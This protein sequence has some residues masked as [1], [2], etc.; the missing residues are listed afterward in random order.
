LKYEPAVKAPTA[1]IDTLAGVLILT[2]TL[3]TF[4]VLHSRQHVWDIAWLIEASRHWLS[5]AVIYR[6][7]IEV[8][9]PLIF[10]E[11]VT[12]TGGI[13]TDA[14]YI[15]GVCVAMALS[16]LWVL[17][18]RGAYVALAAMTAMIV[19]G[20]QDFGQ[21]DHL[22]LIFGL[23]LILRH[24]VSKGEGALLGAWSFLGFGLK[25]YLM[26]IPLADAAARARVARSP[27]LLLQPPYLVL[28]ALGCAY[29][30]A[31]ALF[32]P[33]YFTKMIPLARFVYWAFGIQPTVGFIALS[34]A[35]I[36][37]SIASWREELPL[38]AATVAAVLSF[39]I[40]GRY[41]TYHFVPALG[42]AMMLAFLGSPRKRGFA[43][44]A[45]GLI[46]IQLGQGLPRVPPTRLP[47]GLHSVAILST[48]VRATYP[49]VL[50]RG[51]VNTTRYPALWTLPGAWSI[52]NDPKRSTEDRA[53]AVALL[54]HERAVIRGDILAG[55][56]QIIMADARDKKLYF[57]RPFDY[58]RFLG[59][60]PGYRYAGRFRGYD[61]YIRVDSR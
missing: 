56:P 49:R 36:C 31:V 17:R 32:H 12:L 28:G 4:A 35:T 53:R 13:L 25:P 48:S 24:R 21:R 42:F 10:Y 40:Q 9:P 22:A 44:V 15:G 59:P 29:V 46:G 27:R 52:A 14:A 47:L 7:I 33:L 57:D 60:I 58:M 19:A 45:I 43:A 51:I 8:N 18:L 20:L 3:A 30:V 23:P 54:R 39:Y 11:T 61:H 26:L 1:K 5:G 6:D 34:F 38:A 41:W 2:T 37:L 16:S 55:R 50:D